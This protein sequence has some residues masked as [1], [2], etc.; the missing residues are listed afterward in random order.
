MSLT[1]TISGGRRAW[2]S[3]R[4]GIFKAGRLLISLAVN[5]IRI[6]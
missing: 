2:L 4:S 3:S 5:I 1:G 6:G